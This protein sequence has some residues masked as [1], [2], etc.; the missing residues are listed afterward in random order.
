MPCLQ[1]MHDFAHW[2]GSKPI[3]RANTATNTPALRLCCCAAHSRSA[4]AACDAAAASA[5]LLA[6]P[7]TILPMPA[8]ASCV[9]L[10]S[11]PRRRREIIPLPSYDAS[12]CSSTAAAAALAA[13]SAA[14]SASG[15]GVRSMWNCT[16]IWASLLPRSLEGARRAR[17]HASLPPPGAPTR[18]STPRSPQA[19]AS[20]LRACLPLPRR[21]PS[22]QQC[23][24]R[25]ERS[26]PPPPRPPSA[27]TARSSRPQAAPT[28]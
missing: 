26:P 12:P 24:S 22:L 6:L 11:L 19:S 25:R 1:P 17:R 3:S 16:A 14:A 23:A 13:V 8:A 15:S 9:P 5:S 4:C 2:L 10:E 21:S 20:G 18:P 27:A 7:C 28:R